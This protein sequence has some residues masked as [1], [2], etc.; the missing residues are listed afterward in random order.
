MKE[1]AS[2][3]CGADGTLLSIQLQEPKRG[4]AREGSQARDSRSL[5]PHLFFM[6]S[7]K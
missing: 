4:K 6:Q 1:S 3:Q 2:S 7:D 5:S